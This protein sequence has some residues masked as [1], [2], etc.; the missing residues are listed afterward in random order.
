MVFNYIIWNKNKN[1]F[2]SEKKC[3]IIIIFIKY[4][5]YNMTSFILYYFHYFETGSRKSREHAVSAA[6]K[7]KHQTE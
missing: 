7:A 1:T 2:I 6:E 3:N 4:V 5:T